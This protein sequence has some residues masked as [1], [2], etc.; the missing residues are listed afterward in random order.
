L[1]HFLN[2][3]VSKFR[4]AQPEDLASCVDL[5][6]RLKKIRD[7]RLTVGVES[8]VGIPEK[9]RTLLTA[10]DNYSLG[11]VAVPQTT[12]SEYNS[13]TGLEFHY[14]SVCWKYL[15]RKSNE[16]TTTAP[17][18]PS[19]SIGERDAY[20]CDVMDTFVKKMLERQKAVKFSHVFDEYKRV[21]EKAGAKPCKS[22]TLIKWMVNIWKS[23]MVRDPVVVTKEKAAYWVSRSSTPDTPLSYLS[24]AENGDDDSSGVAPMDTK[25]DSDG[26][27]AVAVDANGKSD[28]VTAALILGS[29]L[30][31]AKA[32]GYEFCADDVSTAE[33]LNS[34]GGNA[35]PLFLYAV[36]KRDVSHIAEIGQDVEEWLKGKVDT[37]SDWLWQRAVT[38]AEQIQFARTNGKVTPPGVAAVG[39][40]LRHRG[41]DGVTHKVLFDKG[42]CISPEI[43]KQLTYTWAGD[44][45]LSPERKLVQLIEANPGAALDF[46]ADNCVRTV[47]AI[48]VAH[49]IALDR[50]HNISP[51]FV[52]VFSRWLRFKIEN[53]IRIGRPRVKRQAA[54]FTS[55]T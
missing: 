20:A 2:G 17:P 37:G 33:S 46:V 5:C 27:A 21:V 8:K 1:S 10:A 45:E 49:L 54:A 48:C 31:E 26:A 34:V 16:I 3:S 24:A 32:P 23:E 41:V 19:A 6:D 43:A 55:L 35:L 4:S 47:S 39:V 50:V 14:H 38:C 15:T 9:Y 22:E 30:D 52:F 51:V 36:L 53:I 29:F 11:S 13:I 12:E 18:P 7:A 28:L 25:R 42:L 40:A 44:P